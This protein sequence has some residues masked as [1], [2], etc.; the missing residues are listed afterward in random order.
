MYYD[1]FLIAPQKTANT[2]LITTAVDLQIFSTKEVDFITREDEEHEEMNINIDKMATQQSYLFLGIPQ[3]HQAYNFLI[4]ML[5]SQLYGR[6]YELGEQ[7]LR[8][9]WHIGYQ[10]G[11]PV[12]DYFDT[13]EQAKEFYE[14]ITENDIIPADYVNNT[15]IYRIIWNDHVYK[16]SVLK[17]PLEKFIRDLDKMYI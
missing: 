1:T 9:K 4:A 7:K 8:N 16:S 14:T 2:I 11:I 13:E 5:Y 6:L 12:F 17:E 3:S 10:V 15:Q